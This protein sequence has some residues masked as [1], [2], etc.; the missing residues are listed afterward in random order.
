MYRTLHVVLAEEDGGDD[1]DLSDEETDYSDGLVE[2]Y[3]LM[4]RNLQSNGRLAGLVKE[5]EFRQQWGFRGRV[6]G[7]KLSPMQVHQLVA[8]FLRLTINLTHIELGT[9][10]HKFTDV[11]SLL[12][13]YEAQI[14]SIWLSQL[15]APAAAFIASHY[16]RLRQF[17]VIGQWENIDQ[18]VIPTP[19]FQLEELLVLEG[20]LSI[21]EVPFLLH[22]S[23]T[24]RSLRINIL[25]ANDLDYK[26]FPNLHSLD[27]CSADSSLSDALDNYE[28]DIWSKLHLLPALEELALE[29]PRFSDPYESILFH[30][31]SW[32]RSKTCQ[33]LRRIRFW[34]EEISID[35]LLCLLT[36]PISRN[37]Q[38]V[39]VYNPLNIYGEEI[40]HR[41][42]Q[43]EAVKGLC[44]RKGIEVIYAGDSH[45]VIE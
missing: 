35:R 42:D 14:E 33:K 16:P 21:E 11:A 4:L 43:V 2:S 5:L 10:C 23:S 22:S 38:E 27:L 3:G 37:I 28:I 25:A 34:S 19:I 40:K 20:G 17:E 13:P 32:N 31:Y 26:N 41:V 6:Q 44:S 30:E 9:G 36:W 39:V 8:S 12:V 15:D 7:L 45:S 18:V 1:E 29:G 24:L